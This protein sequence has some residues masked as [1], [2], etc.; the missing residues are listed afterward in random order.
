M[1]DGEAWFVD[2]NSLAGA[3]DVCTKGKGGSSLFMVHGGAPTGGCCCCG[4]PAPVGNLGGICAGCVTNMLIHS[5]LVNIQHG[6]YYRVWC[7]G[8]RCV[9]RVATQ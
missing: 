8:L 1:G 4:F 3:G 5:C 7:M 6:W 2:D 9:D